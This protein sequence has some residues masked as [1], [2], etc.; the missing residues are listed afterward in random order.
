MSD[1]TFS[2]ATFD[3]LEGL[4]DNNEKSW[5]D[6]NREIYENKV[7]DPFA[8]VLERLSV[9]FQDA[10]LPLQ[11]S[12][13]TMFRITR[14]LRFTKDKRPYSEHVSGL[15]TLSGA[16]SEAGPI[17]YLHLG[18][19]GGFA[20]AGFHQLKATRLKPI[21]ERMIEKADIFDGVI[22]ALDKAGL[23][24]TMEDRVKTMPRGFGEYEDH[25]HAD[26]IRM[27]SLIVRIDL[28]K[29]AWTSGDVLD[30]VER[31]G[32]AATPLLTFGKAAL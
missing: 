27:K 3:W 32:K 2:R 13:K 21:R 24:W 22:A 7:R 5:F 23:D 14:D 1:L 31:F 20:A 8:D 11:G 10:D 4:S 16:K 30:R 25:R 29:V 9:R 28:P 19:D 17:L 26:Y 18:K 15:M 12:S 6:E